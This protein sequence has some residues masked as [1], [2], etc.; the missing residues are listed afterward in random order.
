MKKCLNCGRE[1]ADDVAF[2][3]E[4]G[5]ALQEYTAEPYA[6]AEPLAVAIAEEPVQKSKKGL[7]SLCFTSLSPSP[8]DGI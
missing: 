3:C 1:W 6:E 8:R 5:S 7:C 2:C 4:C